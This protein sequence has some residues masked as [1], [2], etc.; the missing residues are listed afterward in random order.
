MLVAAMDAVVVAAVVVA[1]VVVAIAACAVGGATGV[2]STWPR[3]RAHTLAARN[4]SLA[5]PLDR[6]ESPRGGRLAAR[7][8]RCHGIYREGWG[9]KT[10]CLPTCCCFAGPPG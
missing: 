7:R 9:A 4:G 2:A 6:V 3:L 10:P 8:R 1:A 5:R